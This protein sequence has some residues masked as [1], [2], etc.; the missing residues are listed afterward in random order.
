MA[1]KLFDLRTEIINKHLRVSVTIES[2]VLGLREMWLSI[3]QEYSDFVAY[4]RYDAFLVGIL[5]PAMKYGENIYVDGVV[6]SKLLFNINNYLVHLIKSFSPS[7]KVIEIIANEIT[8]I[9]YGGNGVGTGFSGGVDSFF[10][11]YNHYELEKNPEYKINN[12]LFL[13]VGSH[14]SYNG[15]KVRKKF[16]LRYNYLSKCTEEIG[17]NFIPVDSNLHLFHPWG[18]QKTHTLTSVAGILLF[19]KLF[20]RYY[21][22]SSGIDYND[23]LK[24]AHTYIDVDI[25]VYCDPILL[26]LLST[27]SVE[28]ISDGIQYTLTEKLL[29]IMNYNQVYRYLNVCVSDEDTYKNCSICHKC[30]GTLMTLNLIGKLQEFEQIFDIKK[31]KLKA[32]KKYICEQVLNQ[33]KDP[34]AKYKVKLAE[35]YNFRLP[36]KIL[37]YIVRVSTI[38]KNQFIKL[39][40]FVLPDSIIRYL[41]ELL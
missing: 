28:I 29:K 1:M 25:G 2:E 3:N 18:H 39:T 40:K 11:I 8:S 37:C 23:M 36:N 6:S 12:L 38:L 24:N 20:R 10:T 41:K 30:C 13:N 4:D 31:Y 7:C 34:F 17:L 5:Y 19:Q 32:E 26:P 14:G 9:N 22:A 15:D 33:N 16:Y 27:E 35:E 21:Y